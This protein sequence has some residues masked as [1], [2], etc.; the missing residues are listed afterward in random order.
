M[1]ANTE[2]IISLY[3]G[4]R[5]SIEI[6]QIVGLSPR[7]VRK[8]AI[9]FSLPRL[10][11][12]GRHGEKNHQFVSGRRIDFDG[13]VMV[14]APEDHPYARLRSLRLAKT[15]F[16]H[17]LVMEQGLGRYLLPTEVVDHIDGLTLHNDPANLRLFQK[18]GDHLRETITGLPK[19]ISVS[20][21]R[22]IKTRFD[23]P[24]DWKLVDTF[25][26]RRARGDVRLRQILLAA[27]KLGIDSPFLLGTSHHLKKAQIDC[28]SRSKIEHALAELNQRWE[29]DL[30]Q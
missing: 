14:T 22:N 8:I 23:Q 10:G 11:E 6:A 25:Y 17:R 20:G 13:Y 16:E 21:I 19:R 3:D 27:L 24:E 28:S 1:N 9:K 2:R 7:Y 5:S 18:N 30:A 4:T 29:L 12:G 15:I 26:Q